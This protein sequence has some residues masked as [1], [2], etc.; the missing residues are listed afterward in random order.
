MKPEKCAIMKRKFAEREMKGME[1]ENKPYLAL[2]LTTCLW[3][4]LYVGN[5]F[6]LG[7]LPPY[8]V[9]EGR[10]LA[11]LVAMVPVLLV[12]PRQK[13]EKGDWKYILLL[14]GLGYAVAISMQT[15]GT[16]F[17][18]ASLGSLFNSLNPV[19]IILMAVPLLG[20]KITRSKVLALVSSLIGVY[21]IVGGGLE[22]DIAL[23]IFFSLLSVVLWSFVSVCMRKVT[24]K[25][26]PFM[27]TTYGVVVAFLCLLPVSLG[28]LAAVNFQIQLN[29]KLVLIIAY[30]GI[31]CTGLTHFMWNW[32][33]SRVEA[34]KCSLFYPI[35]PLSAS[36]LGALLLR[37]EVGPRF[38]IGGLLIVGGIL[39]SVLGDRKPAGA[40][41]KGG[42]SNG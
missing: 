5:K 11:A 10:Y 17:S 20:E 1:R 39:I 30:M 16:K 8:T 26:D 37:E 3:G 27:L 42:S 13:L 35:Q 29:W 34:G 40:L 2:L 15:L 24:Q 23:G 21:V 12:R 31:C 18:N 6:V 4:S 36:I 22:G 33:L 7:I 19:V 14:G 41:P 32:A 38:V 28:E 9:L 25:Y